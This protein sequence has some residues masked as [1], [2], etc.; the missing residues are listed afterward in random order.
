LPV[1]MRSLAFGVG[2]AAGSFGQF[3]FS[4]LAVG[5]IDLFGWQQA[6]VAFGVITLAI[7]PLSAAVA[8][9][10]LDAG[11][12]RGSAAS[13]QSLRHAITEAFGHRSYVLL[14]LGFFTCG[15][16]LLFITV[17]LPAYLVDRGLSVDAGAWALGIIGIFNIIGSIGSGWLG[18]RMPKRYLLSTIYTLRS[19]AVIVFISLPVTT[20]SSLIFAAIMGLLWLSTVP[21][22][23]SLVA[24]MFGT[25]WMATLFGF[26]FLSHQVGGFLGVW[27][28]G[29]LFAATGSYDVIWWLS[30]ALGIAS[31]I[32]NL[33]IVEEPLARRAEVA[34]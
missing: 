7:I 17:H 8:T 16:Q 13:E 4:P 22:T 9:P 12:S 11:S 31:A 6:L 5:F 29:V 19:I 21:P 26:A 3:L 23:S 28:G 20:A 32:I 2:T 18:N 34:A 15:F 25:R 1:H 27:L 33:P 14:V 10:P 24:L 30:V